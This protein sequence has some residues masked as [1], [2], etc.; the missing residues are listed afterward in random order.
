[1]A[2]DTTQIFGKATMANRLKIQF[3]DTT[4]TDEAVVYT[5]PGASKGVD[6][7]FDG[8]KYGA[9]IGTLATFTTRDSSLLTFNGIN[10]HT[11]GVDTIGI[12]ATMAANK[13]YK[14]NFQGADEFTGGV[15]GYLLDKFTG[16]VTNV[17]TAPVY[18]FTTTSTPASY[19][20]NR[21]V[22]M[23]STSSS[24]PVQLSYFKAVQHPTTVELKWATASE[25][26]NSHFIVERSLDGR[27]FEEISLVRGNT[28]SVAALTYT[29]IDENPELSGLSYY[30][31]R[32]VDIDGKF[33]YSHVE[34]INYKPMNTEINNL[35]TI[36]PNPVKS[37]KVVLNVQSTTHD[38]SVGIFDLYGKKLSGD[39]T[40]HAGNPVYVIPAEGL[41]QGIYFVRVYDNGTLIENDKFLV[42]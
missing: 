41:R 26:N 20:A 36:S 24:L 18:S 4:V 27:N 14:F 12:R 25:V 2:N 5:Y 42:E 34:V 32:Q 33:T 30:R 17:S 6:E 15:E 11:G 31:L 22:L 28:N 7:D 37:D 9:G 3:M 29:S 16:M 13:T 39:L 8:L 23:L 21:F 35:V 19:D 1:V 38:L 40:I 10:T